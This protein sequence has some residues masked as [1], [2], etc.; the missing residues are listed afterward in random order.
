M[1]TPIS[2]LPFSITQPG[3]YYL[4]GNL[5]GSSGGIDIF[6]DDVTLDLMGFTIDGGGTVNDF[7]VNF[8]ARNNVTIRNGTI[9]RFGMA[10]IYQ[11]NFAP[12]YATI[13]DIQALGNGA[14]GTDTAH[15]GITLFGSNNH[16]ERCTAGDNGG[17][18]IYAYVSS[19]LINNAAHNNRGAYGI[20]GHVGTVLSGN[21]AYS[22]SGHGIYGTSGTTIN[23]NTAYSN[24]GNGIHSSIGSTLSDNTAYANSR[25]GIYAGNSCYIKDNTLYSNNTSATASEGGL[26][27]GYDSRV[28][29]NTLDGNNQ[30]NIYV[31]GSDNALIE[32]HVTDAINGINFILGGNYYRENTAAGNTSN[33]AGVLPTGGGDGGGNAAF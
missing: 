2:S 18:G 26:R 23:G 4:T 32:N 5:D 6:V 25:W 13:M 1:R 24:S 15:S 3:S 33:Y 11:G 12:H 29:G 14:L 16:V 8:S 19:I 30:N 28:V 31:S 7:G 22:N 20:Y 9:K 21:T 27:V 10:G 17:Y